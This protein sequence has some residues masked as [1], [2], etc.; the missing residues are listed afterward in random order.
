MDESGVSQKP[1]LRSTWAPRG[2]T[3]VLEHNFNWKKLSVASALAYRW[4]NKAHELFFETKSG[5]YNG[6]SLVGWFKALRREVPR[7]RCLLVWDQLPAHKSAALKR[8]LERQEGWLEV[9]WL[10]GYAPEL[11]PVEQLWGNVKGTELANLCAGD[12]DEVRRELRSGMRRARRKNL[13]KSF[14]KHA[15]LS[16]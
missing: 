1:P 4:D 15:G 10:P 13:A 16:L 14:L 8:H 3:P 7:R 2:R 9:A 12:L 6:E 11:N 5:S